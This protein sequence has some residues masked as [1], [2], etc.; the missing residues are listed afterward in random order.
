M[1]EEQG[2]EDEERALDSRWH[3]SL[4][5]VEWISGQIEFSIQREY[6]DVRLVPV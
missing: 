4:V 6:K 2:S 1:E 3:F 5:A